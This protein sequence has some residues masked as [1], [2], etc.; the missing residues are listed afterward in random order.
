M[1]GAADPEESM[2]DAMRRREIEEGDIVKLAEAYIAADAQSRARLEPRIKEVGTVLRQN[3][4]VEPLARAVVVLASEIRDNVEPERRDDLYARVVEL[5]IP[6]VVQRIADELGTS[7]REEEVRDALIGVLTRIGTDAA[8]AVADSLGRTDDRAARRAY[9][10]AL[11]KFGRMGMPLV[12]GMLADSRWFV[13]R[14]A[15]TILGEVGGPQ[16]LTHLTAT[17]AHGDPRVRRETVTALTKLGGPDAERLLLSLLTDPEADVRSAATLAVSVLKV[18][19]AVKPLMERL[20]VESDEDSQ[21]EII[22]A[23]GRI[24]DATAVPAIE[25]LTTSG[26]FSRTPMRLRI[27]ALRALGAIGTPHAL[28]VLERAANDRQ[29]D[30]REAARSALRAAEATKP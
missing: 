18:E 27:E 17:L 4:D 5:A 6:Q 21:I 24:G 28:Q 25:K 20:G 7:A 26:L 8:Q 30:V 16:A 22:R 23:L 10:D 13:V 1:M 2:F 14:N 29:A 12:E 9:I 15:V 11:V 3:L 19:R